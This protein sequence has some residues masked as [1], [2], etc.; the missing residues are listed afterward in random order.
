MQQEKIYSQQGN[1]LLLYQICGY[2]H[3]SKKSAREGEC[4]EDGLI[5]TRAGGSSCCKDFG[6]LLV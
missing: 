3:C 4:E 2:I 1:L 5:P 6:V